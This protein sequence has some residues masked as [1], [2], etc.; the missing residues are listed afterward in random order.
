MNLNSKDCTTFTDDDRS[1]NQVV[2]HA[3]CL[4]DSI[5]ILGN[6]ESNIF[7]PF[8]PGKLESLQMPAIVSEGIRNL[9]TPCSFG[10]DMLTKGRGEKRY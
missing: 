3:S 8:N 9:E 1:M 10:S 4:R 2:C 7:Q 6:S 5:L